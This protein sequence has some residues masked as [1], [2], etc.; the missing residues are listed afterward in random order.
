MNRSGQNDVMILD[1]FGSH[2]FDL[3][4]AVSNINELWLQS[5]LQELT[6]TS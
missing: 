5:Y 6:E 3:T 1:V 2:D 4:N